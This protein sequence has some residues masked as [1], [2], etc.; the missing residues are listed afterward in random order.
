MFLV[1]ATLTVSQGVVG[2]RSLNGDHVNS[3]FLFHT[4]LFQS[5]GS[6]IMLFFFIN[7]VLV[8]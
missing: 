7:V 3:L 5:E 4:D 6:S 8:I 1:P 2:A